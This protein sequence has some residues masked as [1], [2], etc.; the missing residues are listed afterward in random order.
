MPL[1]MFLGGIAKGIAGGAAKGAAKKFVTGKKDKKQETTTEQK[2]KTKDLGQKTSKKTKTKS[3]PKTKKVST[4]KLPKN[5]YKDAKEAT[6]P[7]ADSN[8]SYD[9]L[10]KQ[11]DNINKTVGALGA[12]AESERQATKDNLR[13]IRKDAKDK[14]ADD[15]EEQLEKKKKRKGGGILGAIKN[16]GSEFGIG[17]FLTNIAL[18]SLAMFALDNIDKIESLFNQLTTNL[19]NPF[20]FMQAAIVSMSTV[21]AGPIR[22]G[23]R[24]LSKPLKFAGNQVV[25]LAKKIAPMM[26][27]TFAK[28]GT[29]LIGFAK[30]TVGRVTG[31]LGG[32][33]KSATAGVGTA[34]ARKGQ[35]ISKSTSKAA[36]QGGLFRRA[37]NLYGGSKGVAKKGAGRL[38]KL[39]GIFKKVP[40]IGGLLGLFIDLALGEP[41]DRALVNAIGGGLGAWIGAGAGAFLGGGVFSW[42]T[43]PMGGIIG[44]EIGKWAGNQFYDM[45]KQKMGLLPPIDPEDRAKPD[46]PPN[47]TN[48]NTNNNQTTPTVVGQ[49][50]PGSALSFSASIKGNEIDLFQRLILAESLGEGE[51]GMAVVARSVMNRLG[52]I[53]GGKATINTFTANDKTLTGVIMGAGQYSPVTDGSID[54][55]WT[56]AQKAKAQ[57]AIDLAKDPQALRNALIA[58]GV[59]E[60]QVGY[61]IGSTGFRTASAGYDASQDVNPVTFKN[62]IFNTAGNPTARAVAPNTQNTQVAPVTQTTP[63]NAQL[64]TIPAGQTSLT[65]L[66]PFNDF[67]RTLAEGGRGRVGLTDVYDPYGTINKRGRPH[68]G[69][70]IGTNHQTGFGFRFKVTGTVGAHENTSVGGYGIT[71]KAGNM[72]FRS[73]HLARP[74]PLKT[75]DPYNGEVVGE[76]GDTGN[77]D[78]EHLHL[79]VYIN[80]A[81]TDPRPY[82]NY[83]EIGKIGISDGS[84]QIQLSPNQQSSGQ[85]SSVSSRTSY[86]PMSQNYGGG[87]VPFGVPGQSGG[88]GGGGRG[89]SM[90]GPSTQQVL[91]SYYKSQLMGFLYKQG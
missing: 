71:I 66:V 43:A 33:A 70:D 35:S 83:L 38:L 65:N 9:S 75:G 19:S 5:V 41:L 89:L 48:N 45:I 55:P 30:N 15:K 52:L 78:G 31:L 42:L 14:K 27:K 28:I 56:D 63:M 24:L 57:K 13:Q 34:S 67:S 47:N 86:D 12:Q 10:S 51:L 39:G 50:Q 77:S 72:E 40:V 32:G 23:L 69:V 1:P 29:G 74:S 20:K 58:G 16:V 82:L 59:P 81:I 61:L 79:E 87:V 64:T 84:H 68:Y 76:I 46:P 73:L 18:G 6:K 44:Y 7:T 88:G 26:K 36:K 90:G 21:F 54:K 4:V 22:G 3:T 37:K 25:K 8:V 17:K 62:H 11:L 91:N 60:A 85:A 80:G 2:S 49:A 53:Q